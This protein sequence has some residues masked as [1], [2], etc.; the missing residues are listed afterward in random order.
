M[1]TV[2]RKQQPLVTVPADHKDHPR[3]AV[4]GTSS[5]R[6]KYIQH[7]TDVQACTACDLAKLCSRKV[8][9]RGTIP[10]DVLF[11]GEAPGE[12]ED[13]LGLPF[14][15]PAGRILESL[16]CDWQ[17]SRKYRYKPT[18]AVTNIVLCR[19]FP[20]GGEITA[21]PKESIAACRDNLL[22]FLS[23]ANP[24]LVV[25]LGK[26]A[27]SALPSLTSVLRLYH[28]SYILRSGGEGSLEYAKTLLLLK[29]ATS[30]LK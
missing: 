12:V 16:I 29:K 9:A 2:R 28:P 21:P 19:P 8:V 15:G 24:Q 7:Y 30:H 6:A 14:V 22:K 17:A 3:Q 27:Q 10:C 13:A 1:A 23:I 11:I 25:L 26:V 5:A 20:R 4:R 18:Y